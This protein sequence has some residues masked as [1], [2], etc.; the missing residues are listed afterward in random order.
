MTKP[1]VVV[2]GAG[3]SGLMAALRA[4]DQ[5]N[6]TLIAPAASFSERVRWHE[7]A[8]G[9]PDVTH[10]LAAFTKNKRVEHVAARATAID[11]DRREV[12]TDDGQTHTYDRLVYALGSRTRGVDTDDGRVFTTEKASY[13]RKRLNDGPGELTVVGGG[14]TGIEIA[15]ELATQAPGWRVR[16]VTGSEIGP[17]LSGKSR[18]YVR[19]TMAGMGIVLDEG[20]KVTP[21]DIDSDVVVWAASMAPNTALAATA[22]IKLNAGDRVDVDGAL[23]S[24]SHPDIYA[25]GDSAG[26]LR[27]CCAAAIPAGYRAGGN[28]ALD[29]RGEPVKPLRFRYYAVCMSLGRDNGLFQLLRADD[30]PKQT[31]VTGRAGAYLKE[32]IVRGT[33]ASLRFVA[34]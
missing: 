33:V 34:R 5:A 19:S 30:A 32:R 24:T 6:V 27:M 2:L 9:R 13:L 23:R 11:P 16:M 17:R 21:A 15:T 8:A 22:G 10:P 28:V 31:I 14:E 1:N 20:R 29:L 12:R 26:T 18:D 7:L 4:A 25:V 3:Y